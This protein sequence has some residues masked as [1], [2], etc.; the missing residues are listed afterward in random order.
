MTRQTALEKD[1]GVLE[2]TVI[3]CIWMN[4]F[5]TMFHVMFKKDN[6]LTCNTVFFFLFSLR[7]W[8]DPEERIGPLHLVSVAKGGYFY[9]WS[10]E[11]DSLQEASS[12][13]FYLFFLI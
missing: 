1:C 12:V 4:S 2:L 6:H 8:D 13:I 10:M 11:Y 7:L 3:V 5:C 9:G